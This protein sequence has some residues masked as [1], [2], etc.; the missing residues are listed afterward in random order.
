M[1][2]V[3]TVW[4]TRGDVRPEPWMLAMET[5]EKSSL[6][7]V[8]WPWA[9][10]TVAPVT[11]VMLTKKVSVASTLVSPLTVTAKEKVELVARMVWEVRERAT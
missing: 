5:R 3:D 1:P 11:L 7:M 2:C 8:P 6:T 4:P 10:E 9:S